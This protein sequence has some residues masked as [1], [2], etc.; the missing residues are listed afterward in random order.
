[1]LRPRPVP[2]ALLL[3]LRSAAHAD[4]LGE[5]LARVGGN[6]RFE[7]PARADVRL[8]CE[9][10]CQPANA[11]AILVGRGDRLYVEV[12]DGIRA[13]V[14][15]KEVLVVN[16]GRP[17]PAKPGAAVADGDLLLEDLAPFDPSTLKMPQI[18]DQ[19]PAGTVV[20]AAPLGASAYVL[21]VH[22]IAPSDATIVRTQYHRD[23]IG[24]LVK[25]RRN[26]SFVEVGGHRRPQEVTIEH[27]RR[28]TTTRLRLAWR[29][30]PDAPAALFTPDGLA[31]PSGLTWPA[32]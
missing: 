14:R 5:L 6:E 28:G 11:Q 23:V 18:S 21:F 16:R 24:N 17:E 27:F 19:G 13:L 29:E 3:L 9:P 4:P 8:T 22:S 7:A 15:S 12:R 1:M 20:S 26:A 31:K 2:V 25:M 30:F 10:G 32:P